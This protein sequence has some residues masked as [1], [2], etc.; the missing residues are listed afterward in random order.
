MGSVG[1]IVVDM[2]GGTSEEK[3]DLDEVLD[4]N[5]PLIIKPFS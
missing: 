5:E 2:N 4:K 1:Q 3:E